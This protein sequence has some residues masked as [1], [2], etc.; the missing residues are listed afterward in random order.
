M[1]NLLLSMIIQCCWCTSCHVLP[2]RMLSPNKFPS[3]KE[4]TVTTKFD[5]FVCMAEYHTVGLHNEIAFLWWISPN[6]SLHSKIW[7]KKLIESTND[8]PSVQ[9]FQDKE[10]I[11][12]NHFSA[13]RHWSTL[14]IGWWGSD[15]VLVALQKRYPSRYSKSDLLNKIG[16]RWKNGKV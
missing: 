6:D 2:K 1:A 15:R 14:V 12:Q 11:S 3:Y 16:V 4:R 9:S 8:A 10:Q 5:R 7:S 13:S